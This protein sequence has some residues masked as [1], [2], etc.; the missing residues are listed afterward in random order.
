M[1]FNN[2]ADKM[3]GGGGQKTFVFC[4]RSGGGAGANNGKEVCNIEL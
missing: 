1:P 2:Y 3:R 4:S